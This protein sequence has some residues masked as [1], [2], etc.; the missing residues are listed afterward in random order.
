MNKQA[1][2]AMWTAGAVAAALL[3]GACGSDD[4]GSQD[5][6]KGAGDNKPSKSA[7]PS[8]S[9]EPSPDDAPRYKLAKDAKNVFEDMETGDPKKDEALADNRRRINLTDRI[10]TTGK[11]VD[12]LKNYA[13]RQAF[14]AASEYITAYADDKYSWAGVTRYYNHRVEFFSDTKAQI[15]YCVDDSKANDKNLKTGKLDHYDSGKKRDTLETNRV[16][17]NKNG[18]WQAYSSKRKQEAK[19]CEE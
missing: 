5:E 18:I 6:I 11:N 7:E 3:L 16:E 15:T 12:D 19:E 9:S 8:K 13:K 2:T 14:V 4:D 1:S 10:I 17:Q